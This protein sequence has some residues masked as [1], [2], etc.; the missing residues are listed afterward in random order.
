MGFYLKTKGLYL[1]L[2][3][4]YTLSLKY[5]KILLTNAYNYYN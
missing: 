3:F 1:K 4:Y 5:A 2:S